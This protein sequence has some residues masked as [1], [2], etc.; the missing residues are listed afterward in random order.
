MRERRKLILKL[1]IS[2]PIRRQNIENK[3]INIEVPLQLSYQHSNQMVEEKATSAIKSNPKY[4]FASAKK[5]SKDQKQNRTSS[6]RETV[7]HFFIRRNGKHPEE[8]VQRVFTDPKGC[9]AYTQAASTT[10]K[11]TSLIWSSLIA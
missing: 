10:Q 6:Q 4:F 11:P 8:A 1:R 2:S 9:S 5:Q 3:L 7:V